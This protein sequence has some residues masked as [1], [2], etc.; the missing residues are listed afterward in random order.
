VVD[1]IPSIP[2]KS[3]IRKDIKIQQVITTVVDLIVLNRNDEAT[4]S[5]KWHVS[6]TYTTF[7]AN[8]LLLSLS[9]Y[10][11]ILKS[12]VF[13]N[14]DNLLDFCSK[15]VNWC[16]KS[17][18]SNG[19]WG[20]SSEIGGTLEE[21]SYCI[22]LLDYSSKFYP[23][24][25]EIPKALKKARRFIIEHL[26]EA[27]NDNEFFYQKQPLLWIGKQLYSVPNVIRSSILVALWEDN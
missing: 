23:K 19:A 25:S 22:R 10:P 6:P 18:H 26:D 13:K 4:W 9:Q 17:Q 21:T 3:L 16:L 20:F 14:Q 24:N 12:T 5:D 1:S 27:M 15:T 8:N 7:K 11:E 2:S